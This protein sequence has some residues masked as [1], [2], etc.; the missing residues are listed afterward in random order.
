MRVV[1]MRGRRV[2]VDRRCT[3]CRV[4]VLDDGQACFISRILVHKPLLEAIR[5][6]L[7]LL[8][9]IW[10]SCTSKTYSM[11]GIE[12]HLRPTSILAAEDGRRRSQIAVHRNFNSTLS[13]FLFFFP[14]WPRVPAMPS[15]QRED[16]MRREQQQVAGTMSRAMHTSATAFE[17]K[18]SLCSSICCWSRILCHS[19]GGSKTS[20]LLAVSI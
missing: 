20:D 1:V 14:G 16:A 12:M 17:T 10:N 3:V 6:A 8:A 9:F 5:L 4:R 7:C 2:D 11:F 15:S 13:D 18:S 19:C